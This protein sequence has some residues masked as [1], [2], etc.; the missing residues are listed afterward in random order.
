MNRMIIPGG[1]CI[2]ILLASLSVSQVV[3]VR[4]RHD[5]FVSGRWNATNMLSTCSHQCRQLVHQRP[6]H[7]SSCLCDNTCKRSLAI[8]HKSRALCHV[9]RLLS[10]PIWPACAEHAGHIGVSVVKWCEHWPSNTRA[11]GS[12]PEAVT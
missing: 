5:P 3:L 7:V 8:C 10:V 6:F 11:W 1:I 12:V 4:A 9:S 2:N